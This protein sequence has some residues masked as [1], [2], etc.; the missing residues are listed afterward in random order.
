MAP[1]FDIRMPVKVDK[2][3]SLL[4]CVTLPPGWTLD[5]DVVPCVRDSRIASA[6]PFAS[7]D[8]MEATRLDPVVVE[9]TMEAAQL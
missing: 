4:G 2:R 8:I 5:A 6:S 3:S 7:S 9:W 1:G